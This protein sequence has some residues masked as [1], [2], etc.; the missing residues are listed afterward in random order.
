[1]HNKRFLPTTKKCIISGVIVFLE[2][3]NLAIVY[4]NMELI[5]S[6]YNKCCGRENAY[7]EALHFEELKLFLISAVRLIELN[8]G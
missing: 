3:K 8:W 7:H 5:L 4:K 2:I 6:R 1:M